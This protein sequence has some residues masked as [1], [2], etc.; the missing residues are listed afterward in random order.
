MQTD[1]DGLTSH[2]QADDYFDAA[3]Y[4]QA[5]FTSSNFTKVDGG[6]T[7]IDGTLTIKGTSKDI[8]LMADVTDTYL[9]TTYSLDRTQFNVGGPA[10]GLKGVNANVPV[11]IKLIWE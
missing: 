5:T 2:L 10:G 8:T 9:T 11:E 7:Q 6:K 1:S 4:P 3:T